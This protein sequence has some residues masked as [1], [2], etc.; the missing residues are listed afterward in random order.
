MTSDA[1]AGGRTRAL[2]VLLATLAAVALAARLGFWQLDR[3]A[4]KTALQTALVE[5][6]RLSP[7]DAAGLPA[8]AEAAGPLHYRRIEL[9]GRWLA[10]RTVFLDNRQMDGKPGFYVVTPLAVEGSRGAIL[11]ERGWVARNFGER[12]VLPEVPTPTTIVEVAGSLAPSPSRMFEFAPS[13]SG[14]IR[15][16]VD[17]ASFAQETGLAL[18]PAIVVQHDGAATHPADGLLRNWPAPASDVQKHYGY[19]FQ[20]FAIA[21]GI[22]LLHVWYRVIRPRRRRA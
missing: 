18:W 20:W 11:V 13:A 17:I 22:A 4:Q 5:R 14:T 10:D 21:G 12:S 3:A 8:T 2:L 16:N 6:S 19:A 7:L 15:Q 1:R 9:R